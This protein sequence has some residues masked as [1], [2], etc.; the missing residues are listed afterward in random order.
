MPRPVKRHPE[1]R[2]HPIAHTAVE[3][4][5]P[6]NTLRDVKHDCTVKATAL[7]VGVDYDVAWNAYAEAGRK[8]GRGTPD[9]ITEQ[10]F[11]RFGF[12]LVSVRADLEARM[13]E[14]KPNFKFKQL[15]T[16]HP[17][18]FPELWETVPPLL[19]HV[20]KHHAAFK[21]GAVID[22]SAP[23]AKRIIDAFRLE[24]I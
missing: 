2:F 9:H 17:R 19:I 5:Q 15:S 24:P 18:R 4:H 1:P 16:Y 12:R 6:R 3:F 13:A 20:R 23:K 7:L 10:V 22:W 11:A 8:V 14:F 21:D